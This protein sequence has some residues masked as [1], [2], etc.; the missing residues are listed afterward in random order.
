MPSTHIK[1]LPCHPYIARPEVADGGDGLQIWRVGVNILNTQT[2]TAEKGGPQVW[3][4]DE[5]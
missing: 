2:W 1:W 5:G 3:E 4:L